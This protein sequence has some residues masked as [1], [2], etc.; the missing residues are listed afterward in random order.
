MEE[1]EAGRG[2]RA[3]RG[4]RRESEKASPRLLIWTVYL[5]V[6]SERGRAGKRRLR[7]RHDR[8]LVTDRPKHGF[9]LV[10]IKEGQRGVERQGGQIGRA[11]C[12]ERVSSPV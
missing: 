7:R 5:A 2:G 6:A 10:L 8:L 11:S 4:R 9:L 3:E 12:R 1:R